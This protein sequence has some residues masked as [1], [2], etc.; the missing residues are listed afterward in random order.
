MTDVLR[1]RV[2]VVVGHL[3]RNANVPCAVHD[4]VVDLG[5]RESSRVELGVIERGRTEE[6][7]DGAPIGVGSLG[8]T[9]VRDRGDGQ[10]GVDELGSV[11]CGE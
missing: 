7:G 4:Q 10:A 9:Q 6:C 5:A 1:G 8:S 3:D 11:D 2:P